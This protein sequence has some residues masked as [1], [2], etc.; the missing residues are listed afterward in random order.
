MAVLDYCELPVG[1][2]ADEV[3]FYENAFGWRFTSYG[4]DYAAYEE[5]PC[6]LA[7]N[8]TP[9]DQRSRGILPVVRV[10]SIEEAQRA[11]EAAG[12]TIS[13]AIFDYPGG[14]RFHFRDPAGLEL[15]CYEPSPE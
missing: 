5:G 7:L 13:V 12:G 15:A 2:V 3:A 14:R 4:P 6:Q 1:V 9:D 11:V 8:G 10:A